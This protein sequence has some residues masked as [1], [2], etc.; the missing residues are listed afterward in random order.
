MRTLGITRRLAAHAALALVTLLAACG[1]GSDA[2]AAA[3]LPPLGPGESAYDDPAAYSSAADAALS[4]AVEAA[5]VTRHTIE[6]A[7]T[8]IAYT[9]HAGHLIA[10]EPAGGAAQASMFYVAYPPTAWPRRPG[11]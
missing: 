11:R 7:G 3:P 6:L 5:A 4:G 10:R 8:R 9:A 1:G 2:P